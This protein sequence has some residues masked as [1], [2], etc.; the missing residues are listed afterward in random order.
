[1]S[2]SVYMYLHIHV[3]VHVQCICPSTEFSKFTCTLY[4]HIHVCTCMYLY[5]CAGVAAPASRIQP[6]SSQPASYR[7]RSHQSNPVSEPPQQHKQ[8]IPLSVKKPVPQAP[9]V[10]A[11]VPPP[12]SAAAPVSQ[13]EKKEG[14][15]ASSE[16]SVKPGEYAYMYIQCTS[17]RPVISV[18]CA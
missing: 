8:Q 6:P 9:S 18:R 5:V 17:L 15:A 4:I 2:V 12:S 10:P 14:K 13:Q 11:A 16:S 1:M 3:H 7:L